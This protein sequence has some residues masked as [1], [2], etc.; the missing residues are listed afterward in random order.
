MSSQL[1]SELLKRLCLLLELTFE[2]LRKMRLLLAVTWNSE[3][4][5]RMW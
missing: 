1:K 2:L 3:L 5:K 4:L